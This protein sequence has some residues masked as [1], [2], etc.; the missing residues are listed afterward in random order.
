MQNLKKVSKFCGNKISKTMFWSMDF[1]HV[2]LL[3]EREKIRWSVKIVKLRKCQKIEKPIEN[4]NKILRK[5]VILTSSEPFP[6]TL[7]CLYFFTIQKRLHL[8]ININKFGI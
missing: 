6:E 8:L 5:F 3:Q 1:C 4:Y 7:Q 2:T